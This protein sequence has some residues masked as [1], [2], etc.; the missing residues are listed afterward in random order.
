MCSEQPGILWMLSQ[1]MWMHFT[2]ISVGVRIDSLMVLAISL[3]IFLSSIP[4]NSLYEEETILGEIM[5]YEM[6]G[7]YLTEYTVAV[8]CKPLCSPPQVLLVILF[9]LIQ[10]LLSL[11]SVWG[12]LLLLFLHQPICIVLASPLVLHICKLICNPHNSFHVVS[13]LNKAFFHSYSYVFCSM[14]CCLLFAIFDVNMLE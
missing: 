8:Q 1:S 7:F 13:N 14:Y 9:W 5:K 4:Q 2:L 12:F 6:M 10:Y 11:L 3:C